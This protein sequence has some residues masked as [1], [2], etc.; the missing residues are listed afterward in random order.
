MTITFITLQGSPEAGYKAFLHGI[1]Q[2]QLA[3]VLQ[4][5]NSHIVLKSHGYSENPGSRNS[6]LMS[7]YP[8]EVDVYEI[9]EREAGRRFK[10]RGIVSWNAGR[11]KNKTSV[12]LPTFEE[13]DR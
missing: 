7:Y 4:C 10:C 6:G 3:D 13:D 9:I 1:F 5:T 11:G 2:S 8:P 12:V